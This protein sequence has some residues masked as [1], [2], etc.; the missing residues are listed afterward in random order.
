MTE[1]LLSLNPKVAASIIDV[2]A[3]DTSVPLAIHEAANQGA[4]I[5]LLADRSRPHETTTTVPFFGRPAAFPIAP[6]LIAALLDLPVTLI[7]GLY[8]GGER[9]DLY[10]ETF[11]DHIEIPRRERA[12]LL[13]EWAA[14]YAA[15]LEH[16]T[17]LDPYNWFNFYDFWHRPDD[18]AAAGGDAAAHPVA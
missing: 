18:V 4:L 8:R 5:G 3:Q 7:F 6:Y 9:Y 1:L 10:F 15:R 11:A 13:N 16:Y 14:K 17:R 2:G 12:A